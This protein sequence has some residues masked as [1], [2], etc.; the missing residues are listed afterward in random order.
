MRWPGII[1]HLVRKDMV[2][3]RWLMAIYVCAVAA[4]TWVAARPRTEGEGFLVLLLIPLAAGVVAT[5][6]Q[7]DSP[8]SPDA[9]WA[10][11]PIP[12]WT[13]LVAKALA[14]IVVVVVPVMIAQAV[15]MHQLDWLG[16]DAMAVMTR[17]LMSEL[18]MVLVLV[19]LAAVTRTTGAFITTLVVA[20]AGLGQMERMAERL[21]SFPV[22][23]SLASTMIGLSWLVGIAGLGYLYSSRRLGRTRII[24]VVAALV[25]T[26]S[27]E[28][29]EPFDGDGGRPLAAAVIVPNPAGDAA[30]D[31]TIDVQDRQPG[32]RLHLESPWFGRVD[33]AGREFE[34]GWSNQRPV[35]ANNPVPAFP[36]DLGRLVAESGGSDSLVAYLGLSSAEASAI[37]DSGQLVKARAVIVHERPTFSAPVA[38]ASRRSNDTGA[39]LT[40]D[41]TDHAKKRIYL[42]R[43]TVSDNSKP[44]SR[45]PDYFLVNLRR[46]E[47][48]RLHPRGYSSVTLPLPALAFSRR[49]TRAELTWENFHYKDRTSGLTSEWLREA[50]VVV[51]DWTAV[52]RRHLATTI[53]VRGVR[54]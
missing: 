35:Y 54:P 39:G 23:A 52:Q 27:R 42:T 20:L 24:L 40:V 11:R 2:Y 6:V 28:M 13:M 16:L 43:R 25:S 14:C 15:L 8:T 22:P 48:F 50:S 47:A 5:I 51:A 36:G 33:S 37:L 18:S 34:L 41:S 31:V 1:L 7:A 26:A 38:I 21:T 12:S 46:R 44:E 4:L 29:L 45:E 49:T 17:S 53:N 19:A 9:F 32:D 30:L 3:A 10:T